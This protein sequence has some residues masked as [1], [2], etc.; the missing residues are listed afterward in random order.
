[1]GRPSQIDRVPP[2]TSL[3]GS[4]DSDE[5]RFS[6]AENPPMRSLWIRNVAGAERSSAFRRIVM[7]QARRASLCG[8][9]STGPCIKP[10]GENLTL[11]RR[12]DR[13]RRQYTFWP[14]SIPPTQYVYFQPVIRRLNIRKNLLRRIQEYLILCY[15]LHMINA[16]G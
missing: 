9:R 5:G 10:S 16:A 2:R 3:A 4:D 12:I 1:M 8:H 11:P 15:E 13:R 7:P 14:R 6:S